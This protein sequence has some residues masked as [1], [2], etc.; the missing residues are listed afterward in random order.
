MFV[1]LE[2]NSFM[3]NF[4]MNRLYKSP[5][6]AV[7]YLVHAAGVWA[8]MNLAACYPTAA[9]H[10]EPCF[11]SAPKVEFWGD[12]QKPA[13][14]VCC[15]GGILMTICVD[16]LNLHKSPPN[17]EGWRSFHRRKFQCPYR[18][19][20]RGVHTNTRRGYSW[21]VLRRYSRSWAS[22]LRAGMLRAGMLIFLRPSG[23]NKKPR[24]HGSNRTPL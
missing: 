12:G 17:K 13:T 4:A 10:L 6:T 8:K 22:P 20:L 3:M 11:M 21:C 1:E 7:D 18:C 5:S 19:Y 2:V 14:C 23:E 24:N 9:K 15:I 16:R